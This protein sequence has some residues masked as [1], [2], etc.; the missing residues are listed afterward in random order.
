MK[1]SISAQLCQLTPTENTNRQ[2]RDTD[3]VQYLSNLC[4]QK[5]SIFIL[6]LYFLYLQAKNLRGSGHYQAGDTEIQ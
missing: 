1:V 5:V 3:I 4:I 6:Q 2:V